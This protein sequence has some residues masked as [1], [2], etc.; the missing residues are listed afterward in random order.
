ME[1][2][3]TQ[4]SHEEMPLQQTV[5]SCHTQLILIQSLISCQCKFD[6]HILKPKLQNF[7]IHLLLVQSS[8][9]TCHEIRHYIFN[10]VASCLLCGGLCLSIMMYTVT[11]VLFLILS[12]LIIMYEGYFVSTHYTVCGNIFKTAS[13][14]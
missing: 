3:K 14:L 2:R 11:F 4:H 1:N 5:T 13:F 12:L 7:L 6:I 9:K 8:Y 10:F